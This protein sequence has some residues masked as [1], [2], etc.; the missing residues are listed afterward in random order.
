MNFFTKKLLIY[1]KIKFLMKKYSNY[2]K[3][4]FKQQHDSKHR[5]KLFKNLYLVLD[6][7]ICRDF[8]VMFDS[9]DDFLVELIDELVVGIENEPVQLFSSV[10][11]KKFKRS[12]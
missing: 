10:I 8:S 6:C 3:F 1:D 9:F 4:Y 12:L 11:L 2:N 7:I 5:R